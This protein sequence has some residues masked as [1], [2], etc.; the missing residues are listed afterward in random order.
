MNRQAHQTSSYLPALRG[1]GG[2]ARA[3]RGKVMFR[4]AAIVCGSVIVMGIGFAV[5]AEIALSVPLS[6]L[7]SGKLAPI[8]PHLLAT[9]GLASPQRGQ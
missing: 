8:A 5:G 2:V 7:V 3:A 9:N 1:R 4:A 6:V